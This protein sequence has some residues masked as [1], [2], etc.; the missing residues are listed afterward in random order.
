MPRYFFLLHECGTV[1]DDEDGVELDDLEAAHA[2]ALKSA[3]D[4]MC[5][6]ISRGHLCLGCRIEVR[7]GRGETVLELPFRDAVQVTGYSN[8]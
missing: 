8:D 3:R 6:E 1:F 5:G 4:L 7:D 2:V